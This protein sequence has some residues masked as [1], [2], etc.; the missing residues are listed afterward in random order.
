[1]EHL[2]EYFEWTGRSK[3][4][5]FVGKRGPL[6]RRGLQQIWKR[7]IERAELPPELSIHSARHTAATQALKKTQNLR[8]VQKMLGH[9]S[10][11][12]TA[13]MY[14]DISFEDMRDG[15]TGLYPE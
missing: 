15:L 12:T 8:F 7:A 6:T 1:M 5:L 14:A 13:N 4:P 2:R 3:G 10:P 9:S 11:A